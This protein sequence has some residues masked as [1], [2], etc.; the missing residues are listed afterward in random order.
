[1]WVLICHPWGGMPVSASTAAAVTTAD[2]LTWLSLL[3]LLLLRLLLLLL[4]LGSWKQ[5][6]SGRGNAPAAAAAAEAATVRPCMPLLGLAAA[7][8]AP[9]VQGLLQ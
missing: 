9:D 2:V 1:M 4:W 6:G 7:A 3:L 8:A 5:V